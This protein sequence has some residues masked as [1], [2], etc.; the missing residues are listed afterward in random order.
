KFKS[1][2]LVEVADENIGYLDWLQDQPWL[3]PST[4]RTIRAFLSQPQ[5]SAHLDHEC[6]NYDTRCGGK[7]SG[8]TAKPFIPSEQTT[9]FFSLGAPT[10]CNTPQEPRDWQPPLMTKQQVIG[11]NLSSASA[12]I[13]NPGPPCQKMPPRQGL[14]R[15]CRS[16]PQPRGLA[17]WSDPERSDGERNSARPRRGLLVGPA[18]PQS[19]AS[20]ASLFFLACSKR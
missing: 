5:V 6:F 16:P 9:R 20:S 11:D 15:Q 3:W 13:K 8:S 2:T 4:A 10:W 14:S 1:R 12:T 19:V 18:V 7:L 17:E